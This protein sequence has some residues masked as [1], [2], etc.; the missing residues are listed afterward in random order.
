MFKVKEFYKSVN[1]IGRFIHKPVIILRLADINEEYI[2]MTD[3][4]IIEILKTV[5]DYWLLIK[6]S[7]NV[8]P[9]E[10]LGIEKLIKR[11]KEECNL[12]VM[13]YADA[14]KETH[15]LTGIIDYLELFIK[16]PTQD[17]LYK[18]PS[19]H[20]RIG[21]CIVYLN[22]RRDDEIG[23]VLNLDYPNELG[24]LFALPDEKVSYVARAMDITRI[25]FQ[26]PSSRW[27]TTIRAYTVFKD[28]GYFPEKMNSLI[29]RL[30][31]KAVE[32]FSYSRRE[33]YM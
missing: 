12:Y 32:N 2:E 20:G 22:C 19:L 9:Q 29:K 17:N 7:D 33:N 1:Q 18:I 14:L 21:D 25:G 11:I 24:L 31:G 26:L 4:A 5:G 8:A 30:M 15:H 27:S 10:H 28:G 13:L 16:E 23:S 3:E 6:G